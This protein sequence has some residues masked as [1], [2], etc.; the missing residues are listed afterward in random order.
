MFNSFKKLKMNKLSNYGYEPDNID[1]KDERVVNES[2]NQINLIEV[3]K[4]KS[5]EFD[6]D[7]N[8]DE[9]DEFKLY[10]NYLT[11]AENFE[12]GEEVKYI[13]VPIYKN[14]ENHYDDFTPLLN[15]GAK[16]IMN[17]KHILEDYSEGL[18]YIVLDYDSIFGLR[19]LSFQKYNST[20][21]SCEER[22]FFETIII[23]YKSFRYQ[24]FYYSYPK[25]YEELGL[26]KDKAN[27]IVKKFTDLGILNSEIQTTLITNRPSQITYYELNVEK[28]IELIPKIYNSPFHEDVEEKLNIYLRPALVKKPV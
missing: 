12:D 10:D 11:F 8:D 23:K 2:E 18:N 28:I 15:A 14:P 17:K 13:L 25:I 22:V 26:K 9:F 6:D 4:F 7:N 16:V 20:F 5:D 24:K 19:L 27:A 21:F 1:F 3:E